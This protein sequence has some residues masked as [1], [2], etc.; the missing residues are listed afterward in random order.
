MEIT[1]DPETRKISGI[2]FKGKQVI[3]TRGASAIFNPKVDISEFQKA[4]EAQ[5]EF[6]NTPLGRFKNQL[7]DEQGLF[8][9]DRKT[10]QGMY[11]NQQLLNPEVRYNNGDERVELPDLSANDLVR[12][13][14]FKQWA[15]KSL[16]ILS[17]VA[18]AVASAITAVVLVMRSTLKEG[19]KATQQ[20]KKVLDDATKKNDPIFNWI[21]KI[22]E[23]GAQGLNWLSKNL[24]VLA[25]VITFFVFNK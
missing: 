24:W 14:K 13:E 16:F 6:D 25:L 3:I 7:E 8:D 2:Q 5:E 12:L 1:R 4:A 21:S 23:M 20:A 22:A 10:L 17:G 19:E 15:R 11:E 18:I 9:I